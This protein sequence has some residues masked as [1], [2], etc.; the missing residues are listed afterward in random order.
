M[1]RYFTLRLYFQEPEAVKIKPE[2]EI[3][4]HITL[5]S[6]ISGLFALDIFTE[7]VG[8]QVKLVVGVTPPPANILAAGYHCEDI[9]GE[10]YI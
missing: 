5:I 9:Y 7:V 3:S 2:S 8:K 6:I 1:A 10:I 4:S